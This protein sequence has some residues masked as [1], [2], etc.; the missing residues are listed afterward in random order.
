M[1]VRWLRGFARFLAEEDLRTKEALTAW[2]WHSDFDRDFRGRVKYLGPA[3]YSWLVM[4]LGVDTVK[5]DVHLRRFVE[6]V[7]G[8][9][10]SDAEPQ[11]AGP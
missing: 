2:A 5:P 6:R 4:R 9:P 11:A 3:A 1:R 10:V 8:H 7:T